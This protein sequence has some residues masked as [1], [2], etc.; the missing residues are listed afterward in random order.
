[1]PPVQVRGAAQVVPQAP[2][3]LES[4]CSLTH[5]L[6]QSACPPGQLQ[7]LPLQVC[8]AAQALLQSPQ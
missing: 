6:V 1:M 8:A 2:Q 7:V 5:A 3:F 4:V